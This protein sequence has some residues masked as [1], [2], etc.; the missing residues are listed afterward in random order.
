MAKQELS[1]GKWNSG[2]GCMIHSAN[3]KD[4]KSIHFSDEAIVVADLPSKEYWELEDSEAMSEHE[5]CLVW[6]THAE[7]IHEVLAM[8]TP[9]FMQLGLVEYAQSTADEYGKEY[10]DQHD[11]VQEVIETHIDPAEY[12]GNDENH[13]PEIFSMMMTLS[14]GHTFRVYATD[15]IVDVFDIFEAHGCADEFGNMVRS[16][17]REMRMLN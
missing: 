4:G 13:N 3:I 2:G 17:C 6:L 1:W 15:T 9:H 16:F 5:L 7:N 10:L 14:D 11:T 8:I 12:R